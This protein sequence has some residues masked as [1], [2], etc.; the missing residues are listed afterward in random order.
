MSTAGILSQRAGRVTL[1]LKGNLYGEMLP[2][3]NR[4]IDQAIGKSRA[5]EKQFNLDLSEVRL[6]DHEAARFLA[7]QRRRGIELVNC[8]LYLTLWILPH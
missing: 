7:E 4:A 8:P 5:V 1:A 6:V 2:E 3:I